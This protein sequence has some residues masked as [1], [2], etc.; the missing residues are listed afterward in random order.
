MVVVCSALATQ[1]ATPRNVRVLFIGNSLTY[2]NDLPRMV[3]ALGAISGVTVTQEFVTLPNF[4]LGDHLLDGRALAALQRERWDY[5]V[6]QQGPTT[7][8]DSRNDLLRATRAFAAPIR[9]SGARAVLYS[10]WTDRRHAKD[11]ELVS[12]S[13]RMA[14]KSV[15]GLL[16]PAGD[17]WSAAWRSDPKIEFYG[18]DGFHPGAA[19][20]HAAALTMARVLFGPLPAQATS[21]ETARAIAGPSLELTA[22]QLQVI[23]SAVN[24][25]VPTESKARA[26]SD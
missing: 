12:Y 13:Y 25:T 10:V 7:L 5:V 3:V 15:D 11:I 1:G 8:L 16:V 2:V 23:V 19:G 22:T 26:S 20:T 14:A 6:L 18:A 4:S 17:V 21:L 24:K 9:K